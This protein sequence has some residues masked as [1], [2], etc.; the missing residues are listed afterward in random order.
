MQVGKPIQSVVL[1]IGISKYKLPKKLLNISKLFSKIF[2]RLFGHKY[3]KYI[4]EAI[5]TEH[6]F[7]VHCF[8]FSFTQK[9]ESWRK[10]LQFF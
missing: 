5:Y 6:Q 7:F 4:F 1:K 2:S 9:K 3:K 8:S 10:M